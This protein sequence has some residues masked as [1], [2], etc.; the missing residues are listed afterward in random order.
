MDIPEQNLLAVSLIFE[1][2]NGNPVA[3]CES[4][5]I[6]EAGL[7]GVQAEVI[8]RLLVDKLNRG[9]SV[10]A[11]YRSAAYWALSKRFSTRLIPTFVKWLREEI[12]RSEPG[13]IYQLLIALDNFDELASGKDRNGSYSIMDEALNLRDAIFYVKRH[14]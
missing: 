5:L 1:T 12:S 14:T 2:T 7:N 11:S 13:P 4:H 10:A 9:S 6:A 3:D 8:E